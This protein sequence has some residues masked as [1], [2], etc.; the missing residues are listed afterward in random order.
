M[1]RIGD[2]SRIARVSS[3]LLRFYDEIGLFVPAHADPYT[4]YRFYTVGQLSLDLG[5]PRLDALGD[6]AAVLAQKHH[7]GADDRL[8]AIEGCRAGAE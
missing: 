6:F 8:V 2:F 3:R 7:G 4:G 5:N 1:F